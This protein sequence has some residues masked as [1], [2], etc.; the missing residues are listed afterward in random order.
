M[1]KYYSFEERDFA[2]VNKVSFFLKNIE[3]SSDAG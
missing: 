2:A 3:G 1:I